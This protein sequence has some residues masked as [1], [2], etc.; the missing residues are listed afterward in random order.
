MWRLLACLV[1][2]GCS[3]L[4]AVPARAELPTLKG[5]FGDRKFS[6]LVEQGK[7]AIEHHESAKAIASLEEAYRYMPRPGLLYLLGRAALLENRQRSAIDLYRRYLE[8]MGD[9]AEPE[10]K[11]ELSQ[12]TQHP[13]EVGAELTVVGATGGF[14]AVDGYL[15]GSIPL[16]TA[17]QLAAGKHQVVFTKDGRR[18]ESQVSLLPRRA[19]EVRFTLKPPLAVTTLTPGV[20][21]FIDPPTLEPTLLNNLR[22]TVSEAVSRQRAVLVAPELQA[23]AIARNRDLFGCLEQASCQERL[24]KASDAQFA[25]RLSFEQGAAALSVPELQ[26]KAG[27]KPVVAYR[28][29]ATVLD[30]SVGAVASSASDSCFE[31]Q[32]SKLMPRIGDMVQELLKTAANKPRGTLLFTSEPPGASV[33]LGGHSIGETPTKRDAFIG[34][35]DVVFEKSGYYPS[36]SPVLVEENKEQPVTATLLPLPMTTQ[37]PSRSRAILK[38]TTFGV[39]L[40]ATA[41]GATLLA[42]NGRPTAC[43]SDATMTCPFDGRAGGAALLTV[44]T[45]SLGGSLA[46]FILDARQSPTTPSPATAKGLAAPAA[47]LTL[48]ADF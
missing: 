33:T 14:V 22:K 6:G 16:A 36:V 1:V 40:L 27:R 35:Y 34:P 47:G 44:G 39:G 32:C 30:V 12:L 3:V 5:L 2:F 48:S 20:L 15:V 37:S 7:L 24:A 41:A 43:A 28:F 25:L 45:L 17:V 8:L 31:A 13:L 9:E 23:D 21:L 19:A 4:T 38:W 46:L 29:S 10:V 11:A 26:A 18:V 42:L